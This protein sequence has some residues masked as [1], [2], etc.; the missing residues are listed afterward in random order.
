M[1]NADSAL[2]EGQLRLVSSWQVLAALPADVTMFVH[3]LDKGGAIVA[4]H[5]GLDAAAT[6][7]RPGDRLL[8]RH[9]LSL[10]ALSPGEYRLV[11]GLYR[12]GDGLRLPS[13]DGTGAALLARC[14]PAAEGLDCN[15]P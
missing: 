9:V 1:L 3:L 7:L 10:P 11:I 4:Q 8:Q 12:H 15:L 2:G 14:A 13:A 6:T 5:D